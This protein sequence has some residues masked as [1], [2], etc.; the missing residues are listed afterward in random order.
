MR[1]RI[2]IEVL[3]PCFLLIIFLSCEKNSTESSA[4]VPEVVTAEISAITDTSALCGGTITDD[5][6]ETV[7][8][9]G[10][11]WSTDKMPTVADDK[12]TDGTGAGSFTS[13]ITGLTPETTYYHNQ[14]WSD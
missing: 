11:C 2:L 10:V 12:T 13:Y 14:Q 7:T 9:R 1:K 6:G 3:L 5:G 8:A 4:N